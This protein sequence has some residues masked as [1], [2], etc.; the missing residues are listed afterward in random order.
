MII[1]SVDEIPVGSS[2][3]A[4]FCDFDGTVARNDVGYSLFT[5]FSGG[6]NKAM[7]P[8]WKAKKITTRECL[9]READMVKASASEILEFIDQFELDSGFA[10]FVDTCGKHDVPLVIMS[11]GLDIYIEPIL[12]RHGLKELPI[13]CNRGELA[14]NKIKVRFPFTNR[15]CTWCGSCKGERMAEYRV[16]AGDTRLVFVGDGYSDACAATEADILLAKKDLVEYCQAEDIPYNAFD[17]F[18]DVTT[19]LFSADNSVLR[20]ATQRKD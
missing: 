9:T 4:V 6:R 14:D 17:S 5:H 11:E 20:S 16:L 3:I 12:A 2:S 13:I 18:A 8:D 15:N 19:Q 7:I 1:E 10:E